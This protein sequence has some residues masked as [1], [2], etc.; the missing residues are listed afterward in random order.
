LKLR[1]AE[2]SAEVEKLK[3]D[4]GRL[5]AD[6]A[7]ARMTS[8]A[9]PNGA[10]ANTSARTPA[11]AAATSA[12][13]PAAGAESPPP[14]T[15]PHEPTFFMTPPEQPAHPI[16]HWVLGSSIVALGLGFALGW[17]MLDRRIRRKYGGL[18]IY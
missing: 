18:R 13:P 2:R 9:K 11:P 10:P 4:V 16:W 6:L 7:T 15:A 1:L 5:E 8:R 17:Q 14:D 3:Q 12:G